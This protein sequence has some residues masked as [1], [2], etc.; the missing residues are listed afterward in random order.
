MQCGCILSTSPA[1]SLK[2]KKLV[3]WRRGLEREGTRYRYVQN[4]DTIQAGVGRACGFLGVASWLY[5]I[6]GWTACS[7]YGENENVTQ[8]L[9]QRYYDMLGPQSWAQC[10]WCDKWRRVPERNSENSST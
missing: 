8:P 4:N 3:V 1:K 7:F 5:M 2:K 6:T 10:L 9:W